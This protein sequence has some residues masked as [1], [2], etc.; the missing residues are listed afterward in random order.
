MLDTGGRLTYMM[1]KNIIEH[2]T[3]CT[4]VCKTYILYHVSIYNPIPEAELFGSKH[5]ED[6][7]RLKIKILVY[8]T[9]FCSFIL[10]ENKNIVC[11]FRQKGCE[12]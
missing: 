11:R 6:I 4:D 9:C 3:A 10:Y 5:A 12:L 1:D 7:K 2:R 8:N